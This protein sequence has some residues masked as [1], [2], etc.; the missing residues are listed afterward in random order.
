MSH[1]Q[2]TQHLSS[3]LLDACE[4][5]ALALEEPESAAQFAVGAAGLIRAIQEHLDLAQWNQSVDAQ[6][7]VGHVD[8]V[9]SVSGVAADSYHE[10]AFLL[11]DKIF[12]DIAFVASC[13]ARD[14]ARKGVVLRL[15]D[16]RGVINDKLLERHWRYVREYLCSSRCPE[17][18]AKTQTIIAMM[19]DE[20]ALGQRRTSAQG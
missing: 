18:A 6:D 5:K 9:E 11:S 1:R 13:A 8:F 14:D 16:D 20:L 4:L 10:L 2:V 17:F 19:E 12:Q 15:Y 7:Y 3:A